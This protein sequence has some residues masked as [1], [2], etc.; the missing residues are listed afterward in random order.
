MKKV[1]NGLRARLQVE[2]DSKLIQDSYGNKYWRNSKGKLHRTDGPAIEYLLNGSKRWYVDGKK[3]TEEEFNEKM[4]REHKFQIGDKVV[5]RPEGHLGH[6]GVWFQSV[7][8]PMLN[9]I[10]TVKSLAGC[11]HEPAVTVNGD[12]ELEG[13]PGFFWASRFEIANEQIAKVA[14]IQG[15]I[16]AKAPSRCTCGYLVQ[17]HD[18]GTCGGWVR[19]R[20]CAAM[21]INSFPSGYV[22]IRDCW[23][24]EVL[25]L[26][27]R[28]CVDNPGRYIIAGPVRGVTR[29]PEFKMVGLY[30]MNPNW[31]VA[32][33]KIKSLNSRTANKA[34]S[35]PNQVYINHIYE[36]LIQNAT[37]SELLG[38][39]DRLIKVGSE[40][41]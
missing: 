33:E 9:K 41:T 6:N 2:T 25:S 40:R 38:L 34:A 32:G 27:K 12:I 18:K 8:G 13:M 3:L 17:H 36:R 37:P 10:F 7:H 11:S 31:K 23:D 35:S 29:R 24:T 20:Y 16:C 21:M 39:A 28:L 22:W 5:L 1:W 14:L 15:C 19:C 4:N 30:D 26:T